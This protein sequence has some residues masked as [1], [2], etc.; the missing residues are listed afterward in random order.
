MTNVTWAG[1]APNGLM[2][3]HDHDIEECSDEHIGNMTPCDQGAPFFKW[4]RECMSRN[5]C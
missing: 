5:G 3:H 4:M 2:L 1:V